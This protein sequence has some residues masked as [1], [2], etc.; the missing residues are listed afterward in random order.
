MSLA[1]FFTVFVAIGSPQVHVNLAPPAPSPAEILR[2]QDE[3]FLR[4]I[5]LKEHT[6]Q[7]P[8]GL[9][10]STWMTHSRAPYLSA[11]SQEY[12]ARAHLSALRKALGFAH[13][14]A[15]YRA[16]GI[17]WWRGFVRGARILSE[18]Y[19]DP[20]AVDYGLCIQ[21]LANSFKSP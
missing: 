8:Y 9:A 1:H 15:D 11:S 4:A 21:N 2:R 10:R 3:R 12:V 17:C 5:V 13:L 14:P 18:N 16:L 7:N 6:P 20:A 19:P